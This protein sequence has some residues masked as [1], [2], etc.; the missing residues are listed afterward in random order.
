[1][2][3]SQR[4]VVWK[5]SGQVSD[6]C[7]ELMDEVVV[8]GHQKECWCGNFLKATDGMI[9]KEYSG[10][11][12][13]FDEALPQ[14]EKE[15]KLLFFRKKIYFSK[16]QVEQWQASQQMHD[17]Y[18]ILRAGEEPDI[19]A[20]LSKSIETDDAWVVPM[21]KCENFEAK[22]PVFLRISLGVIGLFDVKEPAE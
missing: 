12:S 6:C 15:L 8:S 10:D 7:F 5:S 4:A 11:I 21:S 2:E 13:D 18:D 1:M 17:V 22:D 3:L 16:Y 14:A 19:V 9:E 20:D